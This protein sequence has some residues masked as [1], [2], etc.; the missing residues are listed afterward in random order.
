MQNTAIK[1]PENETS[2]RTWSSGGKGYDEISRGIADAIEHA[3]DRLD[4]KPGER[5]LDVATGT[6]W[7]A[8]RI[9]ERGAR[10]T[11]VD[12][13]ADVIAAARELDPHSDYRVADAE[14]LPFP[15][16]HF[17]GV[18][19]TFGV[20]FAPNPERA[21][22][23]L[24]RVCKPGGR[25]VLATWATN[26]GVF[27]MFD[28]IRSYKRKPAVAPPSPFE[29]GKTERIVELL[30]EAFDLGFEEAISFFRVPDGQAAWDQFLAGFGPVV[31]LLETLDGERA[32]RL[33]RDFIALHEEYRTG[34]GVLLPREYLITVGQLRR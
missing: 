28:L 4:P 22:S 18:L 25:V 26:G 16:G 27:R 5:I 7:A 15:D 12:F 14:A 20:M 31:S 10:V 21:A 8:R 13:G 6:G 24:A 32:A 30:G 17:D 23:E 19:S 34:A 1:I 33:R 2:A 11:G 9:A 3:V 29:W